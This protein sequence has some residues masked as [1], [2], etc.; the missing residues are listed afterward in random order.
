MSPPLDPV[1]ALVSA[2]T[3]GVYERDAVWLLRILPGM[4]SQESGLAGLWPHPW[5]T[6][7]ML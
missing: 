6:G 3:Y 5:D 7:A 1:C 2:C 4:F